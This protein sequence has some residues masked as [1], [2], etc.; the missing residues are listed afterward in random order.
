VLLTL[1][2]P[3]GFTAIAGDLGV[4]MLARSQVQNALDA[5]ALGG[6]AYFDQTSSGVTTAI[7]RATSLVT[8]N[9]SLGQTVTIDSIETGILNESTGNQFTVSSDPTVIN[10]LRINGTRYGVATPFGALLGRDSLNPTTISVAAQPPQVG[11]GSEDCYLP[12][13][14]PD[15][16]L[17]NISNYES[18]GFHFNSANQDNTGWA[19]LTSSAS[20]SAVNNQITATDFCGGLGLAQ[21]G[22]DVYLNNGTLASALSSMD[23]AIEN[24]SKTWSSENKGNWGTLPAQMANS[25]INHTKYGHVIQGPIIMFHDDSGGA[26][27]SATQFNQQK[28]ITGFVWGVIYDVSAN[29][30]DKNI[31][32]KLDLTHKYAVGNSGGG[33]GN[34]GWPPPP[35][36]AQ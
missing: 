35:V 36:L 28:V 4:A 25:S 17:D 29:G 11:A 7:A 31:R 26:C 2:V 18:Q 14:V 22:N 9:H 15:C 10:A 5:G 21:A 3:L 23:S 16:I 6:A 34:V 33:N 19:T 1:G 13:A 30:S 20:A 27:A 8:V 12:L 32:M 24:S